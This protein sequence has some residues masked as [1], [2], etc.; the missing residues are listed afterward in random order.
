MKIFIRKKS[1]DLLEELKEIGYKICPCC[2]L[3]NSVWLE[4]FPGSDEFVHGIGYTD[5]TCPNSV[6]EEL[7]L[8]LR[9]S[10][11][12]IDC[13][14]N[15]SIFMALANY[16]EYTDNMQIFINDTGDFFVHLDDGDEFYTI[17]EVLDRK[18]YHKATPEELIK[19]FSYE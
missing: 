14:E 5:E 1:Q 13:G 15:E 18:S 6:D 8:F 10:K 17:P 9:E 2:H 4:A 19:F 3:P 7:D 16:K 11:D 12:Y